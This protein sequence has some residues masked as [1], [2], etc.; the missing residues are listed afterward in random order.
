MKAI[1]LNDSQRRIIAA[2]LTV[3]A[4]AVI[5]VV[6]HWF[7]TGIASFLMA[8][9]SVLM[10]LAAA[11]ILALVLQPY[12]LWICRHAKRKRVLAVAIVFAS[13]LL[14]VLLLGFAF[15]GMLVGQLKDLLAALPAV[16]DK[17]AVWIEE[18]WP[19]FRPM[20]EDQQGAILTAA[21]HAAISALSAGISAFSAVSGMLGWFVLPIYLAFFLMAPPV[22]VADAEKMLP[23][24]KENTRKD[25]VFLC[26]QFVEIMVSFFRGQLVIGLIQGVMY[27]IG[28]SLVGLRF[29]FILGIVLGFLNIVPYLGS[30]VGLSVC[31]PLALFQAG[32][33]WGHVAL[34][35]AVFSV[36]QFIEGYVLTPKIMGDRT[37]LHPLAIIVAIFFWGTA[38]DGILGMVLAIP[39]TAFLVV[40]WRL[41]KQK[42][43]R[44]W[45]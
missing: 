13:I 11:G 22:K 7:L 12:Y 16:I 9:A 37:G 29:G 3:A 27:A 21:K 31:L 32:G 38:L 17:V 24:F 1:E 18:T 4:L 41:A 25:V 8:F 34:V 23:F 35:L 39:L 19:R 40:F 43:I 5:I 28:F 33:G 20:L 45:I 26:E 36:V 15:G 42:Y 44:E 10:P 30:I 2:A 14:P 6:G